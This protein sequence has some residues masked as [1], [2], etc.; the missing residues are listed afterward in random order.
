MDIIKDIFKF[1]FSLKTEQLTLISLLITLI[2]FI[3][4]K[5]TENKLKIYETRKE[6]Y[7]KLI[8]FFQ[9]IF[10]ENS[11]NKNM[12]IN[13]VVLKKQFYDIGVSLAV[14]G[15]KRL[16][17]TYCFYRALTVD[18]KI[19]ELKWYSQDMIIYSFAEMYKI[20]RVEIG[21]NKDFIPI[22]VP[23]MLAFY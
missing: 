5:R 15:S 12:I 10:A 21:L 23:E 22:A 8:N 2:I 16:Y 3:L 14:F 17:N 13:D 19:R 18:E 1:I 7:K 20:M 4:G 11:K 6:E 9:V